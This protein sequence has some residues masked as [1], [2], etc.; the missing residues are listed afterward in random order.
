MFLSIGGTDAIAGPSLGHAYAQNREQAWTG[1]AVR[2]GA[3]VTGLG[4]MAAFPHSPHGWIPMSSRL[5]STGGKYGR[6]GRGV[7]VG[8]MVVSAAVHLFR[9]TYDLASTPRA[10]RSYNAQ[11][12]VRARIM[13]RVAPARRQ[14]GLTVHVQ[15]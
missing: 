14:V 7:L 13:P 9:T 6:V 1:M 15:F 12:D 3:I 8:V 10:V 2:G 4:A 5:Q 11:P